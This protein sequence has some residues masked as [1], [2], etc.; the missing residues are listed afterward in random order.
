MDFKLKQEYLKNLLIICEKILLD[1]NDKQYNS[2][3]NDILLVNYR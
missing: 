1:K 3:F 2:N